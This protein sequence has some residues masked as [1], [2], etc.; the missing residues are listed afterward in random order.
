LATQLDQLSAVLRLP[1]HPDEEVRVV[2][3]QQHEA[4]LQREIL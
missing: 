3:E 2:V 4:R 1:A